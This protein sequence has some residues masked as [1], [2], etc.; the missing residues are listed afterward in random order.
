M[1]LPVELKEKL[2]ENQIICIGDP[3][4]VYQCF[5]E[6]NDFHINFHIESYFRMWVSTFV[7]ITWYAEETKNLLS[8]VVLSEV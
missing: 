7:D 1:A 5:H 8:E 4:V 3:L 2:L 6:S